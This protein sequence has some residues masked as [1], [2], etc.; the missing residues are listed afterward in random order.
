MM[1]NAGVVLA[2]GKFESIHRGHRALIEETIRRAKQRG[3][4]SAVMVFEPHPITVLGDSN[5]KPLFT[6][7]ERVCLLDEYGLDYIFPCPFNADFAT[8]SPAAFCEK[9]F[10]EYHAREIIVGEDYRFGHN[11]VGTVETLRAEASKYNGD[12]HVIEVMEDSGAVISTSL[13]RNLLSANRL[14]EARKL[15]GFPFFVMGVT[16]KG[17]Q[18][19]RTLGFPT[20]NIY[21]DDD[22]FLLADGVYATRTYIQGEELQSITNIGLR[23][24]VNAPDS[25]VKIR[26]VETFVFDLPEKFLDK[27]LYSLQIKVEFLNF[28]RPERRF[29]SLDDLKAQIQLDIKSIPAF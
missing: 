12:V 14:P 7:P 1:A 16:A 29:D 20:L 26:S 17:R 24:T 9:L 2:I 21:P 4:A 23:P 18:L 13:I 19:G 28:I 15:L 3:L 25:A 5:Y 22:K 27:E 6:G 11:R 10:C 8:L